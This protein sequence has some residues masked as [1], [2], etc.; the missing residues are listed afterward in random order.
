MLQ[1]QWFMSTHHAKYMLLFLVLVIMST[2]FQ[3][4]QIK[5]CHRKVQNLDGLAFGLDFELWT[6]QYI[7]QSSTL[8][9]WIARWQGFNLKVRMRNVCS[10]WQD[11]L[12]AGNCFI[13]SHIGW[14][15]IH[16]DLA[17]NWTRDFL[18]ASLI[19]TLTTELGTLSRF[20]F[21]HAV[22]CTVY[23]RTGFNWVV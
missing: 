13:T 7:I 16:R 4:L 18:N 15:K 12:L 22:R 23:R 8:E 20:F 1:Q 9:L 11:Q 17:E 19:A 3:I 5:Q 10:C 14:E 6:E 2:W 21:I